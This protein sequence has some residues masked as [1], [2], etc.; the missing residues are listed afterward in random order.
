VI[1]V[2]EIALPTVLPAPRGRTRSDGKA[3]R[4]DVRLHFAEPEPLAPGRRV[5]TVRLEDKTVLEDFDVVKAAGGPSKPVVRAFE[6]VEVAGALNLSFAAKRGAPL[7][8]GV[9]IILR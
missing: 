1:G 8:C 6:A 9:E 2:S 4:Y 5:F 3:R 7:L